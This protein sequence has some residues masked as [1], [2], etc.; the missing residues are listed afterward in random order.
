MTDNERQETDHK[1]TNDDLS[2][3][4]NHKNQGCEGAGATAKDFDAVR[5]HTLAKQE[6]GDSSSNC[7]IINEKMMQIGGVGGAGGHRR[8]RQGDYGL[9]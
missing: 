9:V 3:D 6:G 4:F 8:W 1:T 7:G 2:D 5:H